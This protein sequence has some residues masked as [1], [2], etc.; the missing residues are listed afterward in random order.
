[1]PP[2]DFFGF[3]GELIEPQY[4]VDDV[5]GEG[6]FSVVYR[7]HHLGLDEPVAIKCLKIP[8]GL[9]PSMIEAVVERFQA[10]SRIM[11][12]LS[13]GNLNIVRSVS[14]GTAESRVTGATVPYMVLEWLDG[15]SLFQ[16]LKERRARRMIGRTLQETIRLL[17][18]A[19]MALDYAHAQ[20]VVHRDLKP[21]NIFLAET[22]DGTRSKVLD[23][24]LA[25][26]L[27]DDG[28]GLGPAQHT[29]SQGIFC[30]LSYGAPEQ[31]DPKRGPVGPWTDVYS[32]AF[33]IL[34]VLSDKKVR[35]AETMVDAARKAF[36][37]K[38]DLS[39][40]ALGI[41]LPEKIEDLL[42]RA[43][44]VD[45]TQRPPDMHALWGQIK[46]VVKEEGIKVRVRGTYNG[47]ESAP[48]MVTQVGPGSPGFVMPGINPVLGS[49]LGDG[50]LGSPLGDGPL[51]SPLGDGTP[52][53][54]PAPEAPVQVIVN[55]PGSSPE[56]SIPLTRRHSSRPPPNISSVGA[57]VV[58]T[59]TLLSSMG[60]PS[61]PS[62]A[63][64]ETTVPVG[65][66]NGGASATKSAPP[67]DVP[68]PLAPVPA[69]IEKRPSAVAA[70]SAKPAS[71]PRRVMLVA[72]AV[73]V[74]VLVL[75][76]AALARFGAAL[77]G[78]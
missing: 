70:I 3:V 55:D 51:G 78:Q 29:M 53:A 65:S 11:Y 21:G 68:A 30:S 1:M 24:G 71:A 26:I 58:P 57:E 56:V 5:I 34:E 12:R 67:L 44:K 40:T 47:P 38:A 32:F 45:K 4:R 43:V 49:P 59:S 23:F 52:F 16:D 36:D 46:R 19:A 39:A 41:E 2:R 14:S 62:A 33:V 27:S 73:T 60:P 9:T 69:P 6:G 54:G 75:G 10:E 61:P 15:V 48:S 42:F 31:F 13:Q 50:P 72:F 76:L 77:P 63:V 7:G 74:V 66:F 8:A 20:G 25:K 64:H 28:I 37:E 22:R 18:P 35:P 17:D